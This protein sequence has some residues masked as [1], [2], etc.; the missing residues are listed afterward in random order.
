MQILLYYFFMKANIMLAWIG[1]A[2]L[3]GARE[4]MGKDKL[5]PSGMALTTR[6]FSHAFL[7]NNYPER[8]AEEYAR[9]LRKKCS[10]T[11]TVQH[12]PLSK[13]T[14]L[15]EIYEA[16][17]GL[18]NRIRK[19]F[20]GKKYQLTYHLS[21]GTPQMAI[22]WMILANSSFPGTL[23]ESSPNFGV[24]DM[25]CPFEI[26]VNYLPYI[27]KKTEEDILSL[28]QGLPPAGPEFEAIIHRGD[29]LR[30]LITK[31]RRIAI[32]DFPVLIEGESG[33]GKELFARAIH[34]SSIRKEGPFVSVNCGAIPQEL[35]EAEFFGHEK[36]SFTGA[37]K[38]RNGYLLDAHGGTLFLDEI[39]ELPLAAQVKLLRVLQEKAVFR[40]G[41]TEGR[42][43]DFRIIAATN[44]SL[45]N[46]V[47]AGRFRS[48][49]FHRLAVGI[50][51]LPPLR[52]R[53]EDINPLIDHC[54]QR[55]N[56]DCARLP[57]W[58][59]KKIAAGARN[60]IFQHSWPG[61]VRELLN[62]LTRAAIW[63]PKETIRA[64][65]IRGV[66]FSSGPVLPDQDPILNRHI[67]KGFSLPDLLGEV[68]RHYL[69]LAQEETHG[70][71]TK[72]AVL[73]GLPNYQTYSNWLKRY[74]IDG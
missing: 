59:T 14:M 53:K 19:E 15:G 49:L 54:L 41:S 37:V 51:L 47:T 6:P 52:E 71:K 33:T 56:E 72:G 64:E 9:W 17:V 63:T 31:A 8:E 4:E 23:I 38:A 16:A 11:I 70:N 74:G 22:I 43:V 32:L 13:P 69:R 28:S 12:A 18:L 73:L 3:R 66:L 67:G 25:A 10:A 68:S 1:A 7:L 60:A 62:T 5:G 44:R 65:D 34:G 42:T 20:E 27:S 40:I 26:S 50:L 35:V 45:L 29:K 48:D 39:G 21:P 24:N 57:G 58:K 55:I 46:E 61:N 36:G 30:Q 2:D